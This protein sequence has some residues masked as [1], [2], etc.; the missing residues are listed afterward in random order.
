MDITNSSPPPQRPVSHTGSRLAVLVG[1]L[2]ALLALLYLPS[3][4]Q[5]LEYS[6]MRGEVKAIDEAL[7]AD[8]GP[9]LGSLSKAYVLLAKKAAPSVVHIDTKQTE[10]RRSRDIFGGLGIQE[11]EGEASG[12]IV[13]PAGY[14]VTNNH[15]VDGAQEITVTLSNGK[16]YENAEV[17][18]T[19]PGSDLAVIKIPG[20]NLIAAEWG[21]SDDVEVG[22]MVLAIGNP[23]GLDRSVTSGIVSAKNR[24]EVGNGRVEFLQTDAAVNPGNS[25]GPLINMEGRIIGINTAI[26]GQAYQG[27]SFAIPSNAARAAFEQLKKGT[28]STS[29]YLGVGLRRLPPDL[30]QRLGLRAGEGALVREVAPNSP[31]AK[32]GIEIGDVIIAWDDHAIEDAALLQLLV[33]RTKVGTA[34]PVTIVRD[35]KEMKLEVTVGPRP[36]QR[37][38]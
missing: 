32:A 17:I 35:G 1:V 19:D 4:M 33:G 2:L 29:G 12:V 6:K 21:N 5:Q 8:L 15:V 37:S 25:G 13:D 31:A 30:A 18:G 3:Y 38:Q 23:F 20:E 26:V 14:I 11:T 10:L 16:S 24:R 28:P 7:G 22:E 27:I 36:K 9:K 34:V